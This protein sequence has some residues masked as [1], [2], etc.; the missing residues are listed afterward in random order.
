M[1]NIFRKM[2]T[3]FLMVAI[4]LSLAACGVKNEAVKPDKNP[5]KI[6]VDKNY[7]A[8]LKKESGVQAGQV[9]VQNGMVMATMILK[10]N[11]SDKAAKQL[12]DKYAKELKKAYKNMKVNA[13]AVRKGKNIA[14]ITK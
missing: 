8:D 7:T 12:V 4:T 1:N 3:T 11:V 9:Y 5:K 2:V 14:N 6:V 13:Q 10:D